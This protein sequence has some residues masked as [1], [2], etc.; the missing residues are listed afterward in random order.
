MKIVLNTHRGDWV[1]NSW[2]SAKRILTEEHGGLATGMLAN[3]REI[4][5]NGLEFAEYLKDCGFEDNG[6]E[7][8]NTRINLNQQNADWIAI[9]KDYRK[10]QYKKYLDCSESRWAKWFYTDE[11]GNPVLI[12]RAKYED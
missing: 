11:I 8:N 3:C 12:C 1:F 4:E 5:E 9:S 7:Y 6:R 2:E 10:S